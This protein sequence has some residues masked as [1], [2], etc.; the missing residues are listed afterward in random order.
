MAQWP[1]QA[2]PSPYYDPKIKHFDGGIKDS[3]ISEK[4]G[5]HTKMKADVTL[6]SKSA[7]SKLIN[8][9]VQLSIFIQTL[10]H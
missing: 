9:N 5:Q 1:L 7:S 4:T 10:A 6:T 8:I 2:P 3:N